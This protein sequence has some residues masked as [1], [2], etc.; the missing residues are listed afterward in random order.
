MFA[1]VCVANELF[2]PFLTQHSWSVCLYVCVCRMVLDTSLTQAMCQV[3]R[4]KW[5]PS[6]TMLFLTT[7]D[8]THCLDDVDVCGSACDCLFYRQREG[9][10]MCLVRDITLPRSHPHVLLPTARCRYRGGDGVPVHPRRCSSAACP[11]SQLHQRRLRPN[12]PV[13]WLPP[14]HMGTVR[15]LQCYFAGL[16]SPQ[17]R[18]GPSMPDVEACRRSR[19]GWVASF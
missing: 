18:R 15:P 1:R 13:R 5:H 14:P 12:G 17:K 3:N 8:G 10:S 7:S 6:S 16:F 2:L 4:V 19:W 9:W 11:L